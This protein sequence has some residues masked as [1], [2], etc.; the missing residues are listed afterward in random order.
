MQ[1][2]L[3]A[4]YSTQDVAFALQHGNFT[5]FQRELTRAEIS[6][7]PRKRVPGPG[8]GE[9]RYAHI[10]E[11]AFQ[12]AI[13]VKRSKPLGKSVFW[14]FLRELSG[15]DFGIKKLNAMPQEDRN[16]IWHGGSGFEDEDFP[17]GAPHDLA[18]VVDFPSIYFDHDFL[19][20]D[21]ENPTFL[22]FENSPFE[23]SP[24]TVRLAGDMSLIEAHRALID[25]KM[26]HAGSE[27]MAEIIEE[28]FDD[29]SIINL[30]AILKRID[31]RLALRLK[32]RDIR[33]A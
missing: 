14:G 15:N 29:L 21:S 24:A 6:I 12:I 27:S 13:G 5:N 23:G 4:T 22:L 8:G 30:T 25:M 26:P 19:S 33:G 3:K 1:H 11:L 18:Q 10:L 20:R 28:Q 31:D 17:A 9:Y 16:A 2:V 7:L 32:A